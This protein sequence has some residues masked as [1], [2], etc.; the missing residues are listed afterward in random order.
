MIDL[1]GLFDSDDPA[2]LERLREGK[3]LRDGLSRFMLNYQ[4]AIE[5]IMTKINI[6]KTEFQHLHDYSP[7]EHVSSRLKSPESLLEKARRRN[8]PMTFESLSENILD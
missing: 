4:F 3:A 2:M 1:N 8:L 7:I 6:L 5:K